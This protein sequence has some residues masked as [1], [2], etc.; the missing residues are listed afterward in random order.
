MSLDF[1]IYKVHSRWWYRLESAPSISGAWHIMKVSHFS[2]VW[3]FATHGLFLPQAPLSMEF[4]R[5]EDWSGLPCPSSRDLPNSVIKPRPP[6]LQADSLW[7]EPNRCSIK[8]ELLLMASES[9]GRRPQNAYFLTSFKFHQTP[10][11]S[12][13]ICV[14]TLLT[15][16]CVLL[17]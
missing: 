8:R 5:Q 15:V 12:L 6:T 16:C 10:F 14:L 9:N 17:K 13:G 11:L 7:S 4:S 1:S 3:L 2:L